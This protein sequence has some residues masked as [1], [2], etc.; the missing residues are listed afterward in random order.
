M[1][2]D[3]LNEKSSFYDN[4]VFFF[5]GDLFTIILYVPLLVSDY[6]THFIYIR[7]IISNFYIRNDGISKQS[8]EISNDLPSIK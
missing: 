3:Y 7:A 1:I 6:F 5:C 4:I 8:I 2:S